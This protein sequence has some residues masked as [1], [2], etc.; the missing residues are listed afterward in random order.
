MSAQSKTNATSQ[1]ELPLSTSRECSRVC[2]A[3]PFYGVGSEVW[4]ERQLSGFENLNLSL[5]CWESHRDVDQTSGIPLH[6]VPH[7]WQTEKRR[8]RW[9]NRLRRA[10]AGNFFGAS[11]SE[12]R[13]LTDILEKA[14]PEVILCHFGTTALRVLPAARALGIPMVAHF[15]G[16]D[17]SQA[18]RNRWYR[19]SLQ[20]WLDE[21]ASIIVVGSN[22]KRW[23]LE[24]G[25]PENR[26]HQIPCGA[27]TDEFQR[28]GGPYPARPHFL[29]VSR[30]VPWKGVDYS[31]RAFAMA[32]RD[33]L[34]A[35]MQVIGDGPTLDDMKALAAEL[36]L[37]DEITFSGLL[38]PDE[39]KVAMSRA[40]VL[41]QHS[42]D[43]SNGWVEG[44]GVSITEAAAMELPSIVTRCGGITDQVLDGET[45]LVVP[46]RDVPAYA[47]AIS[48][49]GKDAA[50][51]RRLGLAARARAVA[52]F[53][54]REMTR[55]LEAV[56]AQVAREQNA[57]NVGS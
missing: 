7:P 45:G 46:Q 25:I 22:Q 30:L 2:V 42:L 33:G 47:A 26:V 51:H 12:L 40:S 53:D 8:V 39:V 13:S 35:T 5:V 24:Q 54:T 10:P 6:L 36:G 34:D 28:K 44:F 9:L 14:R 56:L 23:V 21:F 27:P 38:P 32:R 1:E 11:G 37:T 18:L 43:Y 52:H 19:W 17:L 31:L 41:L 16:L 50:L 3:Y 49:L 4:I 48:R 55:R 15:H 57:R 20:R 29:T